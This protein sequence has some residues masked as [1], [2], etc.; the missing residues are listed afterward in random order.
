K[1]QGDSGVAARG[2]DDHC[3]GLNCAILFG[4]L[5]HRHPD[6]V[7]HTAERIK[8]FALDS[9]GGF[10]A[11]GDTVQLDQRG[12]ADR[13]DYII[14][15]YAVRLH[16]LIGCNLKA[17]RELLTYTNAGSVQVRSLEMSRAKALATF[18]G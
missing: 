11:V 6:P 17:R 2:F 10:E 8:I 14:I 1:R 18:P 3:V 5:N 12:P 16:C 15:E 4:C 7:L 13:F 9:D